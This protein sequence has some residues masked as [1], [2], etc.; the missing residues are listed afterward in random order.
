M[1]DAAQETTRRFYP[2]P[3]FLEN[4]PRLAFYR[5]SYEGGDEYLDAE[6]PHGHAILAKLD[7]E[8][9]RNYEV[10]R[11]IAT[12]RNVCR[13][14]VDRCNAYVFGRSAA[15]RVTRPEAPDFVKWSKDV[16]RSGTPIG[17]F[18]AERV[19]WAQIE[20]TSWVVV[21]APPDDEVQEGQEEAE[22]GKPQPGDGESEPDDSGPLGGIYLVPVD[23][24][25][26]V[27]WEYDEGT[28]VRFCVLEVHVVKESPFEEASEHRWIRAWTLVKDLATGEELAEVGL[29]ELS[30]V[31]S[32]GWEVKMQ[33]T[34]PPNWPTDRTQEQGRLYKEWVR[35]SFE[36]IPAVECEYPGRKSQ[37]AEIAF[38]Q[39][40]LVNLTSWTDNELGKTFSTV[41]ITGAS[42]ES[43]KQV[44]GSQMSIVTIESP[45]SK[46]VVVGANPDQADSL[47][48]ERELVEKEIAKGANLEA[49]SRSIDTAAPE[50]GEKRKRDL[51]S[52]YQQLGSIATAAESFERAVVAMAGRMGGVETFAKLAEKISYPQEFDVKSVEEL[53]VEIREAQALPFVPDQFLRKRMKEFLRKL[54]GH[55][56]D[57]DALLDSIDSAMP[58]SDQERS[59]R[60]TFLSSQGV[61]SPVDFYMEFY[62]VPEE[63]QGAAEKDASGRPVWTPTDEKE[64][65][66]VA[67]F[68]AKVQE[69]KNALAP[70]LPGL[71]GGFGDNA[72]PAGG[73]PPK[74][75][76]PPGGPPKPAPAP[77]PQPPAPKP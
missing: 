12:V 11:E 54:H 9:Q 21:D 55:E 37:I 71:E 66:W 19:R 56:E 52:L 47:R 29:V 26:V 22:E 76:D 67:E 75:G 46:V 50:S 40:R 69:E 34:P 73:G 59:D 42:D 13:P 14:V 45:E 65:K 43:L 57:L 30:Q 48:L 38:Q 64:R 41:I 77:K 16:D 15:G 1:A 7:R 68:L 23:A 5:A 44:T 49:S 32:E 10:R 35:T 36:E 72:P 62:P 25:N 8:S 63:L 24:E 18:V 60:R 20:G 6:D 58:P 51:E 28:L 31:P 33:T 39:R 4:A 53:L 61:N 74:P 27:D 70:I 3:E 17:V 2:H